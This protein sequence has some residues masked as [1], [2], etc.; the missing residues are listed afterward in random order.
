[1]GVRRAREHGGFPI[2]SPTRFKIIVADDRP[3]DLGQMTCR[4]PRSFFI[5]DPSWVFVSFVTR[6]GSL[7][8]S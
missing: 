5:R 2:A 6:R 7:F 8:H 1:M 3:D 4:G